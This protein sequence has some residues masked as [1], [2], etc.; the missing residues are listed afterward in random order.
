M[1]ALEVELSPSASRS[2]SPERPEHRSSADSA[3]GTE[4]SVSRPGRDEAGGERPPPAVLRP[5]KD[6][7][8]HSREQRR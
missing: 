5:A 6:V 8:G 7:E 2:P 4:R 3:P 1:A